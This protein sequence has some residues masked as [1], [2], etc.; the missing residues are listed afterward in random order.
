MF[1]QK[2]KLLKYYDLTSQITKHENNSPRSQQACQNFV[3]KLTL[4][5]L[6]CSRDQTP[7]PILYLNN[8]GL[9]CSQQ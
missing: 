2:P 8:P 7:Y 4:M 6:N 1:P 9:R 3:T 5:G